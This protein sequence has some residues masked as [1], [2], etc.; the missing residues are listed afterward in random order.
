MKER[1]KQLGNIDN[2]IASFTKRKATLEAE[3]LQVKATAEAE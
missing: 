2:E 3:M 1:L